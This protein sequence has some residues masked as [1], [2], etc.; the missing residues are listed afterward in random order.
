[1]RYFQLAVERHA[2]D[3]IGVVLKTAGV[4]PALAL[5]LGRAVEQAG[6]YRERT[7]QKRIPHNS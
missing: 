1:M 4:A 2:C 7:R 3:E 6:R 5:L